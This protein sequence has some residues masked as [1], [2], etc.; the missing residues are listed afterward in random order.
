MKSTKKAEY[1]LMTR[2]KPLTTSS[3]FKKGKKYPEP[4]RPDEKAAAVFD[5]AGCCIGIK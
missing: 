2:N 3:T 1:L 5:I 4:K